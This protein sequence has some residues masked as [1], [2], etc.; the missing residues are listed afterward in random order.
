MDCHHSRPD[1]HHVA[2]RHCTRSHQEV[3][4]GHAEFEPPNGLLVIVVAIE[5]DRVL[6][7]ALKW[8]K[9]SFIMQCKLC[10]ITSTVLF[11]SL[12]W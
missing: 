2:I 5:E 8:T 1:Y 12:S 10:V 4:Q 6:S 3:R 11:T 7:I 9:T